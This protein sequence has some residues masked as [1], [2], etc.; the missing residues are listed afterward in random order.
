M[1]TLV[2]LEQQAAEL[3]RG[4][5]R[6]V[7]KFEVDD[8][9][10]VERLVEIGRMAETIKMLEDENKQ[11]RDQLKLAK[12]VFAVGVAVRKRLFTH[13]RA[14]REPG[15]AD[16]IGQGNHAAHRGRPHAD[17]VLCTQVFEPR[18]QACEDFVDLYG[19]HPSWALTWLHLAAV[20][21]V[22][23]RRGSLVLERIPLSKTFRELFEQFINRVEERGER[24]VG[25][26]MTWSMCYDL[27]KEY[28][29]LVA[30]T[31]GQKMMR[32]T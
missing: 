1:Y 25:D 15:D 24:V 30:A 22:L 13:A 11:L 4:E 6:C 27:M 21:C 17:A 3:R 20:G 28:D 7:E 8:V 26:L 29:R 5:A 16:N 9:E 2:N 31:G 19:V 32:L 18:E 23:E 14:R 10:D 12:P